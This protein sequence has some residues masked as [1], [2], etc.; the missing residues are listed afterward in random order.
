MPARAQICTEKQNG[1]VAHAPSEHHKIIGNTDVDTG[2]QVPECQTLVMVLI[3]PCQYKSA[4]LSAPYTSEGVTRSQWSL[5]LCV[6]RRWQE[7]G[8]P[9][10]KGLRRCHQITR[11]QSPDPCACFGYYLLRR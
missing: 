5:R 11:T 10:G 3:A 4:D 7:M 6:Q 8:E 1:F 9:L 2:H